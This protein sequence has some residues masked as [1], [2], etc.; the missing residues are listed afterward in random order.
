MITKETNFY[1]LLARMDVTTGAVA[2]FHIRYA[3]CIY[4]DGVLIDTKIGIPQPVNA[5]QLAA[6]M[7]TQDLQT[8]VTAFQAELDARN[9]A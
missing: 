8:I 2:G 4:D 9:N 6:V 1:E 5:A 7:Q 3:D